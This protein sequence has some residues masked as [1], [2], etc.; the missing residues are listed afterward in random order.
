MVI[1][2]VCIFLLLK[3]WWQKHW[4]MILLCFYKPQKKILKGVYKFGII[5][6]GF[7]VAYKLEEVLPNLLYGEWFR[8]FGMIR[9]NDY[10]RINLL[11]FGIFIRCWCC[12]GLT[13]WL[14][15]YSI[16]SQI[17]VLEV[18]IMVIS[19]MTQSDAMH[20]GTYKIIHFTITY[21]GLRRHYK[22]CCNL[23]G[24]CCGGREKR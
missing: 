20:F 21:L 12:K 13:D 14:N 4:L 18:L 19:C 7:R 2:W 16:E 8:M 17:Y 24:S 1:F 10:T 9:D 23:F 15:W 11:A 5:C 22:Y 6:L 3:N